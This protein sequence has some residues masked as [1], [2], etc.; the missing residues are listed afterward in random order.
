MILLA[1]LTLRFTSLSDRGGA[2]VERILVGGIFDMLNEALEIVVYLH[3]LDLQCDF[4]VN[5]VRY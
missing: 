4:S 1:L 3:E 5:L 2:L